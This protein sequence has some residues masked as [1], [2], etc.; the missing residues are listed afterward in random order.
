MDMLKACPVYSWELKKRISS[1][2]GH[3]SNEAL[4][5]WLSNDYDGSARDIVL[6][7]L[8]QRANEPH[9]ARLTA[10]TSLQARHPLF[11]AETNISLSYHDVPTEWIEF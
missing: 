9:L 4:S 11:K 3:L 6:T 8:S 1:N 10:E 2:I 7:H 5:E